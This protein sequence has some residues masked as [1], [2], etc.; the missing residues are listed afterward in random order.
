MKIR[1]PVY[2]MV[3]FIKIIKFQRFPINTYFVK[4]TKQLLKIFKKIWAHLR[5]IQYLYKEKIWKL[6][7]SQDSVAYQ[8]GWDPFLTSIDDASQNA[9]GDL[10]L[11]R[12]CQGPYDLNKLWADKHSVGASKQSGSKWGSFSFTVISSA[13]LSLLSLSPPKTTTQHFKF[14]FSIKRRCIESDLILLE[15]GFF[16]TKFLNSSVS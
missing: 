1:F 2:S 15:V 6:E 8:M 10:W 16:R 9:Q 3:D 5:H 12:A 14:F 11:T 4:K 13:T 7:S